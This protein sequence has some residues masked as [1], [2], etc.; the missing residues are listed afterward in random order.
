MATQ[1][2]NPPTGF[3]RP[4]GDELKKSA[5]VPGSIIPPAG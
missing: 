2:F 1:R 5:D 3:R 4:H